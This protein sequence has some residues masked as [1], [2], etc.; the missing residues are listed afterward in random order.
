MSH[1]VDGEIALDLNG[2]GYR[3]PN[4]AELLSDLTL[5]LHPGEILAVAGLNGA[6]K[7]TLLRLLAGLL[8]PTAGTIELHGKR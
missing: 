3:A 6:G 5:H 8:T 7:T 2:L 1:K 4:G